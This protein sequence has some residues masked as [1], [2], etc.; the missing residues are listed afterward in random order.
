MIFLLQEPPTIASY[1]AQK[2]TPESVD[3]VYLDI[4]AKRSLL[5]TVICLMW[6]RLHS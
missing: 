1:H 5:N 6:S 2:T 4:N 3:V